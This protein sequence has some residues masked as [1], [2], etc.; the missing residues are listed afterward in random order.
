LLLAVTSPLAWRALIVTIR[1]LLDRWSLPVAVCALLHGWALIYTRRGLLRRRGLIAAIL[2]GLHWR[3][4]ARTHTGLDVQVFGP[5][6]IN[7]QCADQNSANAENRGEIAH[8]GPPGSG[9]SPHL[10]VRMPDR[11]AVFK[12]R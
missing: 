12:C 11:C 10:K 8:L 4:Y 9:L 5:D 1:A 6:G 3:P 2:G 7:R